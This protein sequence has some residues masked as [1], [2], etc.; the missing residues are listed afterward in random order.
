MRVRSAT[1]IPMVVAMTMFLGLL[2]G[3]TSWAGGLTL[4]EVGTPD[5]G[6]ASAGYGARA[7]DASTV[8]TNPAGMTRLEGTQLLIGAQTLHMDEKFTAEQGTSLGLG[9]DNGGNPIGWFPGGSVFMTQTV[10]TDLAIGFGIAGN[11][12]LVEKYN[13]DWI[14]RYY[15]QEATLLGVS[16]LPSIAYRVSSSLS[17]GLSVNAMYGKL[18]NQVA[19]NNI[20]G[21]D[22]QLKLEDSVWGW[23]PTWVCSMRL[24]PA[25]GSGSRIILR[26]S[27]TSPHQQSSPDSRQVS[28]RCSDSAAC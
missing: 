27:S 24:I 22:G 4:Y 21:P 13:D 20:I 28:M 3:G 17:F 23:G 16:L 1:N 2:G 18:K 6:L 11:F 9:S 14:G 26:S 19:V 10:S 15:V 25:Q 8:L 5:V 12:G 7:Q